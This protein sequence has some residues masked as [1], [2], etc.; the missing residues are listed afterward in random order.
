ME[1]K[2]QKG[3]PEEEWP[4]EIEI[5]NRWLTAIN[6]RLTLDRAIT[7]NKYGKK[8]LRQNVVLDT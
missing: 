8:A 7:S 2:M 1:A 4:H 6:A 3:Q 5:H